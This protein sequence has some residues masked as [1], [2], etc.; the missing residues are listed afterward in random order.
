M[1]RGGSQPG[2]RRSPGRP[3]GARNKKTKEMMA[4][5]E[6]AGITPIDW[7]LAVLRDENASVERRDEM[8]KAA[9]PYIHPRLQTTK[10]QGDPNAPLFDLT[11][12]TDSELA[13][14]RRTILKAQ[15]VEE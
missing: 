4:R 15:Q 12:L 13:F 11:T 3:K 2:E 10:V 9:A 6:A 1:P 7:M 14:L 8:A 5:V